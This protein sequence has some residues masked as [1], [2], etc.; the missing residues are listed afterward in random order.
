MTHKFHN[1]I[2]RLLIRCILATHVCSN[3]LTLRTFRPHL[4]AVIHIGP[5]KTG[6]TSLQ[7]FLVQNRASI[8]NQSYHWLGN[9]PKA[10]RTVADR[11]RAIPWETVKTTRSYLGECFL[12]YQRIDTAVRTHRLSKE[13]LLFSSEDFSFFRENDAQKLRMFMQGY[14]VSVVMVYRHWILHQYSY[15]NQFA[16]QFR[17]P[18]FFDEWL[19]A[20][21]LNDP[22]TGAYRCRFSGGVSVGEGADGGRKLSRWDSVRIA[23]S[24]SIH[25]LSP[26]LFLELVNSFSAV[27]GPQ[28]VTVVDYY[29]TLARGRLMQDILLCEVMGLCGA[30]SNSSEST[31]LGDRALQEEGGSGHPNATPDSPAP[32]LALNQGVDLVQVQMVWLFQEYVSSQGCRFRAHPRRFL[33]R[34]SSLIH[35]GMQLPVKRRTLSRELRERSEAVDEAFR[36]RIGT[37]RPDMLLYGDLSANKLAVSSFSFSELDRA[38][39]RAIHSCGPIDCEK[40]RGRT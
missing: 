25:C 20:S 12:S 11:V 24:S 17:G 21:Y 29:G 39:L 19:Q 2:I 22:D 31:F 26:Q 14:R 3:S 5:W 38:V 16:K 28:Q 15:F 4:N 10:H 40:W 30:N 34:N 35:W 27:F 33:D 7:N 1:N 13:N 32:S 6:T 36:D 9:C 23:P 37:L 18:V 8:R